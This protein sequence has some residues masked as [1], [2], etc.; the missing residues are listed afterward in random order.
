MYTGF[1]V[2]IR[3]P[4][5]FSFDER[6]TIGGEWRRTEKRSDVWK[7]SKELGRMMSADKTPMST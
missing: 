3:K 1:S 4:I 7:Y 5:K 2:Y 6:K